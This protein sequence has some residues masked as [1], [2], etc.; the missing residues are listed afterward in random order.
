MTWLAENIGSIIL[1]VAI[2]GIV[3]GIVVHKIKS[4]KK[5]ESNCGCGCQN[6]SMSEMCHSKN[7]E[8]GK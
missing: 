3:V 7:T 2:V 6:C 8:Q 1:C 5:G 4:K